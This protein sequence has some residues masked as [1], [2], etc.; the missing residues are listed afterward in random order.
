[1]QYIR[2]AHSPWPIRSSES[3]VPIGSIRG[4]ARRRCPSA[5]PPADG[6]GLVSG[7][8]RS[9]VPVGGAGR[10]CRSAVP[11]GGAG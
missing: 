5:V 8:C 3:A 7:A 4:G 9:A 11:V 2:H 6:A 10:R 1:M